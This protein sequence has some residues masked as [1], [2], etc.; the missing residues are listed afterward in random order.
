MTEKSKSTLSFSS[1][2]EVTGTYVHR[3]KLVMS[4]TTALGYHRTVQY[5]RIETIR[6]CQSYIYVYFLYMYVSYS[7]IPFKN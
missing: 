7:N 1:I 3:V 6:V 4:D 2:S 5:F